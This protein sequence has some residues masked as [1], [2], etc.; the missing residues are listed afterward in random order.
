MSRTLRWL[1][2]SLL[3]AA[4]LVGC[5]EDDPPFQDRNCGDMVVLRCRWNAATMR[6]DLECV[7]IPPDAGTASCD[8]GAPG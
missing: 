3:L 8:G 6:Y 2:L 5:G 7:T 1:P 4:G